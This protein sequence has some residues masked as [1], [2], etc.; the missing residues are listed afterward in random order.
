MDHADYQLPN[1]NSRVKYLLDYVACND[2]PFQA[3]TTMVRNEQGTD[4]MIST[5]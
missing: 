2:A 5:L 3:V 4:G 1:G